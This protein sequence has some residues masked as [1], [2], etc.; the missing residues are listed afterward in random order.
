MQINA[1]SPNNLQKYVDESFNTL[2]K[3]YNYRGHRVRSSLAEPTG[4]LQALASS[5]GKQSNHRLYEAK[6]LRKALAPSSTTNAPGGLPPRYTRSG[7]L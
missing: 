6:P 2:I 3:K 1:K 5:T 4:T 7:Q